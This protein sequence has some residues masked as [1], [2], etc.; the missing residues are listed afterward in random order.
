MKLDIIFLRNSFRHP[1]CCFAKTSTDILRPLIRNNAIAGDGVHISMS[2]CQSP[3]LDF[4][5]IFS[6]VEFLSY[7]HCYIV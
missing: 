7:F 1:N 2:G 3:A 5:V 4:Q 6:Y